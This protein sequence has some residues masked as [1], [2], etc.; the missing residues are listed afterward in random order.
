MSNA[1]LVLPEL[2]T[3]K[4]FSYLTD[5]DVRRVILANGKDGKIF[6]NMAVS[7]DHHDRLPKCWD[8]W[9]SNEMTVYTK[10]GAPQP[11]DGACVCKKK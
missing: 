5:K 2:V 8:C 10:N 7:K 3:D 4:I 6:D 1:K 9:K 11:R